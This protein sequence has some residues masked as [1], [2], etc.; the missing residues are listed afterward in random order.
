V[1]G[2]CTFPPGVCDGVSCCDSFGACWNG[3]NSHSLSI[4]LTRVITTC[5]CTINGGTNVCFTENNS[6]STSCAGTFCTSGVWIDPSQ[7]SNLTYCFSCQDFPSPLN[8]PTGTFALG[9]C[10]FGC[11]G[12]GSTCSPRGINY[13]ENCGGQGTYTYTK[14]L[15]SCG[16]G[17]TSYV[18]SRVS[19][20][21]ASPNVCSP[22]PYNWTGTCSLTV[23]TDDAKPVWG[24]C[25]TSVPTN[26]KTYIYIKNWE[27]NVATFDCGYPQVGYASGVGATDSRFLGSTGCT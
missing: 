27:N 15:N 24:D 16:Y 6:I 10:N 23:L 2:Q 1:G 21:N 26:G 22:S 9:G 18:E 3:S 17:T 20:G 13:V 5:G 11:D 19:S 8:V 25:P 12:D 4:N 7:P 14:T